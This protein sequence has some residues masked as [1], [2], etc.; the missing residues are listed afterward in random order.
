[1][2]VKSICLCTLV[3]ILL[4]FTPV[5]GEE[6]P[7]LPLGP[8]HVPATESMPA[9]GP[10]APVT[11]PSDPVSLMPMP[12]A[13]PMPNELA[14]QPGIPVVSP[15]L[16]SWITGSKPCCCDPI[17]GDGPLYYEMY[18]G[19]VSPFRSVGLSWLGQ[20]SQAGR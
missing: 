19:T 17:G 20:W 14:V 1:M 3:L 15:G 12:N 6:D 11:L 13:T 8:L 9:A 2:S 18:F 4:G 7:L 16:S 10:A 5:R